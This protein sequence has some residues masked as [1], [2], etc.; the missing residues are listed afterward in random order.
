MQMDWIYIYIYIYTCVF[1][2][3]LLFMD[4]EI[5]DGCH[6][7]RKPHIY[8]DLPCHF[9]LTSQLSHLDVFQHLVSSHEWVQA[10]QI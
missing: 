4:F 8:D 5:L 6:D 3:N 1:L 2:I 7:R 10:L 9:L